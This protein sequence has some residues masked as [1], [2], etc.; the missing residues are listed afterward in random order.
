MKQQDYMD[1]LELELRR[2]NIG[3]LQ[4]VL[5]DYREHFS[6]ALAKG[7]SEE[8]ICEK[9]GEPGLV[10]KAYQAENLMSQMQEAAGQD[11]V[12]YFIRA[13]L[14][15]IILTPFN[16]FMM[17]GPFLVTVV[18]LIVGWA[19]T[20]SLGG[21]GVGISLALLAAVPLTA[22]GF[23]SGGAILFASLTV[24]GLSAIG[25]FIMI[26]VTKIILHLFIRY[27]YWNVSFVKGTGK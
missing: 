6:A 26:F 11:Q 2:L 21:S 24:L 4:D 10:A 17:I 25:L 22:I 3:K 23:W 5:S 12:G 27:L 9:L 16:F 8:E 14:R 1:K 18:M 13:V 20:V 15:I 7:K 19:L